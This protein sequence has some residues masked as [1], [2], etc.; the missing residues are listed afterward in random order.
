MFLRVRLPVLAG[1]VLL[2]LSLADVA[3][4]MLFGLGH[5]VAGWLPLPVMAL[6]AAYAGRRAARRTD[7]PA[8]TRR[9][10]RHFSWCLALL[11]VGVVLNA[12]DA[13]A[14]GGPTQSIGPV[15]SACYLLVLAIA[16]FAL[17]RLPVGQRSRGD[18]ARFGLDVGVIL[19][20]TGVLVW[21]F[22]HQ[23]GRRRGSPRPGRRGR[24]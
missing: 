18:W 14:P 24:C 3:A 17:L 15:T 4:E 13:L 11:A 7:L 19:I 2:V 12:R 6:L 20:T 1:A 23:P 10:W 21:H 9:F 16:V 5:P 22:A 8:T